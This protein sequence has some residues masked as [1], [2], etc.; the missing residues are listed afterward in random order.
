MCAQI[1]TTHFEWTLALAATMIVAAAVTILQMRYWNLALP[2]RVA[3]RWAALSAVAI[4]VLAGGY[5]LVRSA[6]T[7][8]D[9]IYAGRNFYGT[10]AVYE[11][12]RDDPKWH[13]R[14]F[15]SGSTA[16]GKQLVEQ[17]K[18][19]MPISYFGPN[20]GV[21]R[22]LRYFQSRPDTRIG[23]V[24]MGVGVVATYAKPGHYV[25]FYEINDQVDF[26]AHH[27][28]TYLNDCEGKCDVVLADARLALEQELAA[29]KPQ[30]FNVLAL[31]AFNGDA[32]PVHLLTKEAF[33][34]YLKHLEPDG[35]IV[36][37]ITNRYINLAPVVNAVAK[38]YGLGVTRI[39]TRFERE[40][41]LNRTDFM[42]LS[43][44][45]AFL[46]AN[47]PEL[48][49]EN[50]QPEYEVPLWTDKFSN[51]LTILEEIAG[52]ISISQ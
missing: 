9:Q 50:L 19:K 27:Y 13:R 23:V 46:A 8:S 21:G 12:D 52:R 14:T 30:H 5:W 43:R 18:R 2:G 28:F 7:S 45:Q 39:M 38:E 48:V 15:F 47:P 3:G 40:K 10:V 51:L 36:V 26:I 22:T 24:G 32:P 20:T 31:D 37:N 29:G 11:V 25:R 16:H 34:V 44:N 33:A 4:G 6:E 1:F 49:A 42:M 35:V 17:D 41:L